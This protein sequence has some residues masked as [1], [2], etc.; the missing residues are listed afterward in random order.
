M[1]SKAFGFKTD[2]RLD[3]SFE[4]RKISKICTFCEENKILIS[5][6]I[7][8][9]SIKTYF[10]SVWNEENELIFSFL[11]HIWYR[12]QRIGGK[13]KNWFE[14]EHDKFWKSS[15]INIYSWKNHDLFLE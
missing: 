1:N 10:K 15:N 3:L 2:E 12:N 6:K 14:I 13:N 9:N 5:I 4:M 7:I 8:L 11:T